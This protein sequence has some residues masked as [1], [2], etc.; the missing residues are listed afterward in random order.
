MNENKVTIKNP[1][2]GQK[3]LSLRSRWIYH[4]CYDFKFFYQFL[5][6]SMKLRFL[7]GV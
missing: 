2:F 3:E 4:I 1:I 6:G 5:K 7:S